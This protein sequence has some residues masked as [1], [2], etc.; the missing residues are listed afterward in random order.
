VSGLLVGL[1]L[2]GSIAFA[3][4]P[5]KLIVNGRQVVCDSPPQIINGRVMVP[6]RNVAEPLGATVKWDAANQSVIITSKVT[7]TTDNPEKAEFLKISAEADALI[8]KYETRLEGSISES[9][10]GSIRSEIETMGARLYKW[11][12]LSRYTTIKSLY[13]D[14][15]EYLGKACINKAFVNDEYVGKEAQNNLNT[16]LHN[17]KI[18]KNQIE[19][20]K[21]RLQKLGY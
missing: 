16:N 11:G 1:L 17:F 2:S 6:A 3:G 5:I 18:K 8:A 7:A 4:S 19:G 10:I 12:E 13:I 21:T 15:L 20:E 14:A 9:E